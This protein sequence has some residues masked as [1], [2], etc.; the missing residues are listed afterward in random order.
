MANLFLKR[1]TEYLRDDAGFLSIIAPEPLYAFFERHAKAGTLFDRLCM[2]I[3]SPGSGKTTLSTLLQYNIVETLLRN[4]NREEYKPILQALSKCGILENGEVKVIGCRIPLE[5]DFREFWE[6]PYKDEVKIG[7]YKSFLQARTIIGWMKNIEANGGYDFNNVEIIYRK[8]QEG[9]AESVGGCKALDVLRVAKLKEKAI[10]EISAALIAPEE[11]NLAKDAISPYRP[12]EIIEAFQI[13]R[14]NSNNQFK[15]IPLV[16]LDDAHSL[17]PN[18][19]I[20]TQEW[21]AKREMQIA[22]WL[23]MR[24]DA[25]TPEQV[26]NNYRIPSNSDKG[27]LISKNR[28]ITTVLMQGNNSRRQQRENFREMAKNMSNKY[29]RLMPVFN[30]HGIISFSD[31]LSEHNHPMPNSKID[32]IKDDIEKVQHKYSISLRI[33]DEFNKAIEQYFLKTKKNDNSIEI[34]LSMLL[35]MLHRYANRVPQAS[36]FSPVEH[37]NKKNSIKPVKPNSAMLDG[38]RLHLMHKYGR[39]YYYGIDIICYGSSE[40]AELF[41][42][43]AGAL[44]EIAETR[45]IKYPNKKVELE[46]NLQHDKLVE[47]SN[48]IIDEWSFPYFSDVKR[49]CNYIALHCR[50]KA[51]EPNASLGGGPNAFGILQDEFDKIHME[52]PK[53]ANIIKYGVAYNAFSLKPKSLVKHQMWCLIEL[54]GTVIIANGLTLMRG[55]FLEKNASDL[56]KAIESP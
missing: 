52:H 46:P 44:V 38:A 4:A 35:I 47:K 17:H 29:L 18:Q 15:L 11:N 25:Q 51:L 8:G 41:L 26:I 30:K 6:L 27:S 56:L 12:F 7:L 40:N 36:L 33:R 55:G 24:L 9:A 2:V 53:L 39:A 37:E 14:S 3:G 21:L 19:F 31:L 5:S 32:L 20:A 10:Y 23:L 48:K 42:M 22:R 1:T 45:I 49:L 16:M 54:S 13:S 43:L 28:E 50:E 34:R